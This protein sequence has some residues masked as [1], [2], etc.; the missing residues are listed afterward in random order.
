MA[1]EDGRERA[2][3]DREKARH[4]GLDHR[5][6]GALGDRREAIDEDDEDRSAFLATFAQTKREARD[7]YRRFVLDGASADSV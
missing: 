2:E 7:A 1:C 5:I 6:P 3:H 4:A